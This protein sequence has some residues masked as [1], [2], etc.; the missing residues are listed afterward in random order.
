MNAN[1]RE[2]VSHSAADT[3][4]FAAQLAREF[5]PGAV[6]ALHGDLGAGKTCL[7]QGLGRALGVREPV[8][9]PTF[10]LVN[11]YRG[12]LPLH[13][14]DLY[15]LHSAAEAFGLGLD[16]YLDGE[17]V[18]VI[19]W[20]ERAASLLPARTIHVELRPGAG[21]TERLIRT[22]QGDAP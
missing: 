6:V 15:R 13:H 9:S 21:P 5:V 1:A 2:F 16:E 18:T 11:E 3:W 10:T 17:G 19:E 7:V 12:R 20:A 14:I 22:W 4:A 8:H